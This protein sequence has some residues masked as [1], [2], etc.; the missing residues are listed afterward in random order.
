MA[1]EAG[2]VDLRIVGRNLMVS[3]L[4]RKAVLLVIAV[5]IVI[6]IGWYWHWQ[7]LVSRWRK[8]KHF[9]L[10]VK[11]KVGRMEEEVDW[12]L[13]RK[14]VGS[15]LSLKKEVALDTLA[16]LVAVAVVLEL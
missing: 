16:S 9:D 11:K 4:A 1:V 7:C 3:S 14:M 2:E 15:C 12:N 5:R 13:L 8:W 10:I 6:A